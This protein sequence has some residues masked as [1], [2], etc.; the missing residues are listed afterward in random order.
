[1]RWFYLLDLSLLKSTKS[2]IYTTS[3]SIVLSGKQLPCCIGRALEDKGLATTL[4]QA[5]DDLL[6]ALSKHI[7]NTQLVSNRWI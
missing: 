3:I 6:A 5:E 1:M 2:K 7:L 4:Y